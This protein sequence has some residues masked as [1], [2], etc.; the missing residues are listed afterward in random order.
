MKYELIDTLHR[1][2]IKMVKMTTDQFA[3][4]E[5]NFDENAVV[6]LY[7]SLKLVPDFEHNLIAVINDFTF[8]T[9][10]KQFLLI[11]TTYDFHIGNDFQLRNKPWYHFFNYIEDKVTI[12]KELLYHLIMLTVCTTRGVL[13]AKVDST[14]FNRLNIPYID[15]SELIKMDSLFETEN[16]IV[17]F[18]TLQLSRITKFVYDCNSYNYY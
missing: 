8:E 5:R 17:H 9:S 15:T 11:K 18:I 6:K 14:Y 10:N 13:H 16:N 12:T 3:L 1:S 2:E 4:I 7:S